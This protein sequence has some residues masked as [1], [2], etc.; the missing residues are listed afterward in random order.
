[1]S[2]KKF[3]EIQKKN[4]EILKKRVEA[5]SNSDE[6]ED[7]LEESGKSKIQALFVNYQGDDSQTKKLCDFLENGENADC[8]ICKIHLQK[9]DHSLTESLSRHQTG[10]KQGSD[11]EL[12]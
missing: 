6:S 12:P 9:F 11:M 4:L 1:M 3:A 5:F 8:L 10:A 7:E 2:N